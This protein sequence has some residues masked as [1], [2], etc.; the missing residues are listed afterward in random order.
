MLLKNFES[1]IKIYCSLNNVY[2]DLICSLFDS[3]NFLILQR[4]LFTTWPLISGALH[5]CSVIKRSPRFLIYVILSKCL[6]Y[7]YIYDCCFFLSLVYQIT[8]LL[9][10][11][12]SHFEFTFLSFPSLLCFFPSIISTNGACNFLEST[13]L[14]NLLIRSP[15]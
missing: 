12:I 2:L 7:N 13:Y 8:H 1:A 11:Y 4:T 6:L 5:R 15:L 9:T 3:S 14:G 10:A